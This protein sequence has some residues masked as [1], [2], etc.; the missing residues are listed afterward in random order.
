MTIPTKNIKHSVLKIYVS[1]NFKRAN[2]FLILN[3]KTMH[4]AIT[5]LQIIAYLAV[6]TFVVVALI[7][8]FMPNGLFTLLKDIIPRINKIMPM[9]DD[10]LASEKCTTEENVAYV[11][12]TNVG[13]IVFDIACIGKPGVPQTPYSTAGQIFYTVMN[14]EKTVRNIV[15]IIS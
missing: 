15:E 2:I 11:P 12:K 10:I 6:I 4:V 3:I 7:A 5:I 1:S 14:I 8:F 13:K 9:I